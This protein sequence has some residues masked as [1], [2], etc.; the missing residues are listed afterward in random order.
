VRFSGCD[1]PGKETWRELGLIVRT[2]SR[3][4]PAATGL[5]SPFADYVFA[6]ISIMWPISLCAMSTFPAEEGLGP[7]PQGHISS[8]HVTP[9]SSYSR[10]G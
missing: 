1:G 9:C 5:S 8:S 10:R 7:S 3:D 2:R 4:R 6:H